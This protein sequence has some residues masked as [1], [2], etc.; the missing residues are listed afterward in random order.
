VGALRDKGLKLYFS[1]VRMGPGG[2]EAAEA[3]V[4]V[5]SD[6]MERDGGPGFGDRPLKVLTRGM[7]GFGQTYHHDMHLSARKALFPRP[8]PCVPAMRVCRTLCRFSHR[9]FIVLH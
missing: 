2:E 8:S 5:H 9:Q 7:W 1:P 6:T 4:T 3:G